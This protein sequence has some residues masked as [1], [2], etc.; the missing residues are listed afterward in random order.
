MFRCELGNLLTDYRITKSQRQNYSLWNVHKVFLAF[1]ILPASFRNLTVTIVILFKPTLM[2]SLSCSHKK[3]IQILILYD[4]VLHDN[5]RTLFFI[6]QKVK[7]NNIFISDYFHDQRK[8][9]T[10]LPFL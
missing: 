1:E 9:K 6:E 5:N 10:G 3:M 2:L 7:V 4:Y 8:L